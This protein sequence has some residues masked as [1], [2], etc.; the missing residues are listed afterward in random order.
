MTF[1][2]SPTFAVSNV[3][4]PC[5]YLHKEPVSKLEYAADRN[6]YAYL[7]CLIPSSSPRTH[8][9]HNGLPY[10]IVPRMIFDT[11]RP[12]DPRRTVVHS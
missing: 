6:T 10:C 5:S 11:F 12:D 4:I 2:S 3:W 7:M 9:C 1:G 8:G